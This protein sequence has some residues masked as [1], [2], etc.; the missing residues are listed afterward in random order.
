MSLKKPFTILWGAIWLIATQAIAAPPP[1]ESDVRKECSGNSGADMRL[2]VENKAQAS[3]L[4]LKKAERSAHKRLA[5]WDE[6]KQYIALAQA[7][8]KAANME[9]IR[10]RTAQCSFN[11]A[12]T[13]GSNGWEMYRNACLAE[14]N[15]RRAAQ[16]QGLVSNL[17]QISK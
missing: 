2:C 10:Y 3:A 13:G 12:Q 14:L 6:D 17:P 9:F 5:T 11:A 15:L 8:L 1:T 16:I 7:R 4:T